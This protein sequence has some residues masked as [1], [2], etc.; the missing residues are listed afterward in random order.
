MLKIS[1]S[2]KKAYTL[3][4][5]SIVLV[6]IAI[7]LSSGLNIFTNNIIQTKT[8]NTKE[9]LNII[10]KSLAEYL[11]INKRL[12]CPI[13]LT[14]AKDTNINYGITTIASTSF[15]NCATATTGANSV[16]IGAVPTRDLQ[17]PS[18]MAE[19][20]FGNKILY[21]IDTKISQVSTSLTTPFLLINGQG[22]INIIGTATATVQPVLLLLSYGANSC[23]ATKTNGQ[24]NDACTVNDGTEQ[25]ANTNSDN[26][27]FTTSTDPKF[28]DV[29]ITKTYYDLLQELNLTNNQSQS[30]F[31]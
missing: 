9:K 30:Y 24:P 31:R 29:I 10:Y 1:F 13:N 12:P 28:D 3:V 18:D 8:T 22:S 26:I 25:L 14:L 15:S 6:I 5:L 27:F 19:D 11:M 20:D 2:T 16:I 23:G 7:F 21:V 4:E 17:L